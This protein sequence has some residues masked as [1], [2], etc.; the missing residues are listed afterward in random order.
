MAKELWNN[1][2]EPV[3]RKSDAWN[4]PENIMCPTAAQPYI[5]TNM[6]SDIDVE[7]YPYYGKS[8]AAGLRLSLTAL[9]LSL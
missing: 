3:G 4:P 2:L 1:M 5:F 6:N 8:S 9:F 7:E